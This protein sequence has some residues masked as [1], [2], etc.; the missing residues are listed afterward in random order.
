MIPETTILPPDERILR[1]QPVPA[2]MPLYECAYDPRVR[3]VFMWGGR[4][5]AKS[6]AMADFF[7]AHGRHD[8]ANYLCTREIQNS[9]AESVL[10][11]IRESIQRLGIPGYHDTE[12]G[13]RHQNGNR[14]I[15]AGVGYRKGI[16]VKS[17]TNIRRCW[18]EEAQQVSND[19][20]EVL[21]PTVRDHG[22]Q[23]YYTFNRTAPIDPV[24]LLFSSYRTKSE[25]LKWEAPSGKILR[26][27][28]H[29]GDGVVG[30]N[31]NYDGN[32]FFPNVL[33]R[34]RVHAYR[35]AMESGRWGTYNHVWRGMPSELGEDAI[36]TLKQ[37]MEAARRKPN[38]EGEI[39]VG[40]DVARGGK[41]RVVFY[42]RK[43]LAVIDKR[44]YENNPDEEP[45]RITTTAERVE[46]FVGGDKSIRI[47]VDDT[48]LGG[49]VT[50]ILL[51]KGYS[52]VPVT[53]G[54]NASD[55]DHY[56]NNIA[57]MWF[58]F[59]TII[60]SVSIPNE[61][62]LIEELTQRKEG[63]RD[64]R[65]RRTVETKDDFKARIGRSPDEAD[66]LLL[67]FY[68]PGHIVSEMD[69]AIY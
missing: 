36:L 14:M 33:E 45:R 31:I 42:K 26:W 65:G 8:K 43:G 18:V 68:E 46:T 55:T 39:E 7:V 13:I 22:S 62:G 53:F 51:D 27:V 23:I 12:K 59:A 34:E 41:D 47:K 52:V 56:T 63:R 44:I 9:L 6:F 1:V 21:I 58:N 5:G 19:S 4:G 30:I 38:T 35:L 11:Q 49:G 24:W 2:F 16:H 32:P 28:L 15:F 40:V 67:A 29:W 57:E 69:W 48:G 20:L 25:K 50:D 61:N 37:A 3:S 17:T 60:D 64:K 10:G 54:A 66:A